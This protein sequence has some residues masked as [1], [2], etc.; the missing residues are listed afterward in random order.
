MSGKI[1]LTE[2]MVKEISGSLQ[3]G[4]NCYLHKKI[5]KII[6]HMEGADFDPAWDE[7]GSYTQ[8]LQ[9]LEDSPDDYVMLSP[10]SSSQAY[11][12]ME[13]FAN[14]LEIGTLKVKLLNALNQKHPFQN[15][16][17][18]VESSDAR[19]NWFDFWNAAYADYVREEYKWEMESE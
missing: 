5:G 9:D 17:R 8:D 14:S 15:F 4:T 7:E 12:V 11:N 10:M 18:L 19:Q 13:D 16:K 6:E 2:E 1:T 3:T